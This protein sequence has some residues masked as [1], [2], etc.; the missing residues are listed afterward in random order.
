MPWLSGRGGGGQT[1]NGAG[2]GQALRFLTQAGERALAVP[3]VRVADLRAV[4]WAGL[5]ASGF[6]VRESGGGVVGVGA[7]Q[8]GDE[9]CLWTTGCVHVLWRRGSPGSAWSR[10]RDAT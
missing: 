10:T 1:W 7:H 8:C 3:H 4:D 6:K 2:A 5:K 9:P